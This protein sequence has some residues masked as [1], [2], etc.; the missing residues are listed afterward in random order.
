MSAKAKLIRKALVNVKRTSVDI[1]GVFNSVKM[2][3]DRGHFS[4]FRL[5]MTNENSDLWFFHYGLP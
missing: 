4:E 3:T 5:V 2:S 1:M